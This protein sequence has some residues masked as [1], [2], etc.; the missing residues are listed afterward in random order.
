MGRCGLASDRS[1]ILLFRNIPVGEVCPPALNFAREIIED[2]ASVPGP[3]YGVSAMSV[4]P[5]AILPAIRQIDR[6]R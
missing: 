1:L 5:P 4:N 3:G 2:G 6:L